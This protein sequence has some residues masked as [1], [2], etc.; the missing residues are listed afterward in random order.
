MRNR[1]RFSIATLLL[2]AVACA[3]VSNWF[4]YTSE[5]LQEGGEEWTEM[6]ILTSSIAL[7]EASYPQDRWDL[8]AIA[9]GEGHYCH[10]SEGVHFLGTTG[11]SYFSLGV[12]LP[13]DLYD[14]WSTELKN[15]VDRPDGNVR[16]LVSGEIIAM[17]FG[18]PTSWKLVSGSDVSMGTLTVLKINKEHATIKVT[19][20]IPLRGM[21]ETESEVVLDIDRTFELDIMWPEDP[22]AVI[23]RKSRVSK[24]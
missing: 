6:G 20:K 2:L 15:I 10:I 12:Q 5:V 14:G 7:V 22:L 13:I 19:A 1:F 16:R 24:R 23:P 4:V 11:G 21:I 18:N 8:C 17:Q 3:L 9:S